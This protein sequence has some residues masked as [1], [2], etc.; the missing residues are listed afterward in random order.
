MSESVMTYADLASSKFN[1]LSAP[2][3]LPGVCSVC[4]TSRNDDRQYVDFGLTVDMIGVIYFCT[5]CIQELCNRMGCLT[6]EQSRHLE[7]QLDAARQEILSFQK[8]KAAVDNVISTLRSTGLF[9]D[10]VDPYPDVTTETILES[11][12][13]SQQ[14]IVRSEPEASRSNS[15]SKQSNSKQRS[16]D[17]SATTDDDFSDFL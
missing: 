16:N 12:N 11:T 9:S 5:M 2:E 13:L 7:D 17:L 1:I 10:S 14:D 8:E 15:K 4:G 3:Q 6:P